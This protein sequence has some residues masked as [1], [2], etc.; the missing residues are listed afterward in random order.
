MTNPT[1]PATGDLS[2]VI[3]ACFV[4]ERELA[5]QAQRLEGTLSYPP[6]AQT[7]DDANH[8]RRVL[9]EYNDTSH[10]IRKLRRHLRRRMEERVREARQSYTP[11]RLA[12]LRD[13]LDRMDGKGEVPVDWLERQFEHPLAELRLIAATE[14]GRPYGTSPQG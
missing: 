12:E 11:T 4:V 5:F 3:D 10:G 14:P 2:R 9:R 6:D 13:L 8:L 1:V 7:P